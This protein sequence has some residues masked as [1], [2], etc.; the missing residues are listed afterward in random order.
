MAKKIC[1]ILL[2]LLLACI[3]VAKGRKSLYS[4]NSKDEVPSVF[5]STDGDGICKS[6]VET[7]GYKCEEHKVCHI[8]MYVCMYPC[9]HV[10]MYPCMYVCI[11]LRRTK[12][13][14]N[15]IIFLGNDV[16]NCKF[17]CL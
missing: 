1:L 15:M 6:M 14:T 4:L 7:Q 13:S 5:R 16:Q 17:P 11:C 2:S 3:T 12:D 8:C 9:M 10:C